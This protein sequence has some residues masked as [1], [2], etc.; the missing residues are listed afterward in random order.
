MDSEGSA[1]LHCI[2]QL[3]FSELSTILLLN[4]LKFP[5]LDMHADPHK[6]NLE[7]CKYM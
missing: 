1:L 7:V 4:R 6:S 3:Y 5:F 2:H